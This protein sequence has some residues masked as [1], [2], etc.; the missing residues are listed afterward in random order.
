[1][2]KLNLVFTISGMA[3]LAAC[4]PLKVDQLPP[5]TPTDFLLDIKA[6]ADA[7]DFTNID[8]VGKRL[9]IDLV[10]GREKP[11]YGSD[12]T[13][14]LGYGVDIEEKGMAPEYT[15]VNFHYGIFRPKDRSFDRA[16]VSLSVNQEIICATQI[17]LKN[18]FKEIRKSISPHISLPSY[19]YDGVT[20]GD[21]TY[22]KFSLD[23]CLRDFS[24][25]KNN[26]RK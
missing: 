6:V 18:V 9:K 13:T 16:L 24:F 21:W 25:Y 8:V 14:L 26:G 11:V 7:N 15:S 2:K 3:T 17:D 22:F 23:G 1:M 19:S 5:R 12:E 4:A 20:D 10:S